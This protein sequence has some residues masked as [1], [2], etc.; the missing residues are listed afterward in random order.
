MLNIYN[1][2]VENTSTLKWTLFILDYLKYWFSTFLTKN[3]I[4]QAKTAVVK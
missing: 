4:F 3:P 2:S 1:N